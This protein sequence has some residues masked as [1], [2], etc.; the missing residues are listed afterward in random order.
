MVGAPA[1]DRHRCG[2]DDTAEEDST[3]PSRPT[4]GIRHI[5]DEQRNEDPCAEEDELIRRA[6]RPSMSLRLELPAG[7]ARG[8]RSSSDHRQERKT[9]TGL[10]GR[11]GSGVRNR[12]ATFQRL[13]PGSEV[14]AGRSTVQLEPSGDSKWRCS[15]RASGGVGGRKR[16]M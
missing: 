1:N 15:V 11:A 8:V 7:C 13:A 12:R 16:A 9:L 4:D 6:H 10:G 14:E 2:A 5:R 3:H